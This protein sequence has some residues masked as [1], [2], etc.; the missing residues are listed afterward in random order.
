[1][2]D[3]A[4]TR[5]VSRLRFSVLQ[6]VGSLLTAAT[7]VSGCARESS[8]PPPASAPQAAAEVTPTKASAPEAPAKATEQ[9]A[10]AAPAD[11]V[12]IGESAADAT[13]ALARD[14]MTPAGQSLAGVR[15]R[16]DQSI[17]AR[18]VAA[19]EHEQTFVVLW[20]KVRAADNKLKALAEVAADVLVV[21][22]PTQVRELDW[23][24]RHTKLGAEG[25]DGQT[26]REIPRAEWAAAIEALHNDGWKLEEIEFHH[27]KFDPAADG[28]PAHSIMAS[29]FFL[30]N[31]PRETRMI[32]RGDLAIEWT[33]KRDQAGNPI[34]ARLDTANF[35]VFERSGPPP[36]K[37]WASWPFVTDP[38]GKSAPSTPHPILVYDLDGDGLSEV[39]IGG[40][41][42]VFK[43]QGK[44]TF[45]EPQQLCAQ[46]PKHVNTGIFADF[47]GDGLVDYLAGQ[48]RGYL[49]LYL[50]HDKGQFD[51]AGREIRATGSE[52]LLP[53]SLTAGDIDG[54][55]DLDVWV[56]QYKPPYVDGAMPTP[57]YDANDGFPSY[58]LINDGA[59]N[60]TDGT[61][62]AGLDKKRLRRT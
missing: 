3:S 28:K 56:G 48:K 34:P 45:S 57:Y 16:L 36:F 51:A 10:A 19:Q 29:V 1:M 50:G 27:S 35:Q 52:L 30:V 20:D 39:T 7:L 40:F 41:N 12:I 44:G 32:V 8:A 46:P 5:H 61:A 13:R 18:E 49:Q 17:W 31:E 2:R 54:D 53:T 37:R 4:C 22:Q 6:T 33:G 21:G 47:N 15:D 43:N 38:T 11:G 23:G 62:A 26:A 59:G 58:L 24:I 9:L 14:K 25:S 60:F 55:G 42:Q